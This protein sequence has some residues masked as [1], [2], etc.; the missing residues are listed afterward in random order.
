MDV[1]R[2]SS[3]SE[4]STSG[5]SG[6]YHVEG[7]TQPEPI[8]E[9]DSDDSAPEGAKEGGPLGGRLLGGGGHG[10][11]GFRGGNA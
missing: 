7:E 4:A 2:T 10:I 1:E 5:S 8:I 11:R 6:L 9:M 3:G